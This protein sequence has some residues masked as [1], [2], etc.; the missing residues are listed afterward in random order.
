MFF[1]HEWFG[2]DG[3]KL[4]EVFNPNK[5]VE[6]QAEMIVTACFSAGMLLCEEDFDNFI[7]STPNLTTDD[8]GNFKST[9]IKENSSPASS[10]ILTL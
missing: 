5:D 4:H 10:H 3:M 7:S 2:K 1:K 9:F 6:K 8:I